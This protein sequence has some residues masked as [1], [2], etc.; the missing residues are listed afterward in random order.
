MF[1]KKIDFPKNNKGELEQIVAVKINF[2]L[3]EG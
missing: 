1:R 3:L 2:L